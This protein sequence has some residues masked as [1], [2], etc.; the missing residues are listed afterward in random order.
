MLLLCDVFVSV[1]VF[2]Y[3]SACFS[4]SR[5]HTAIF[6]A[7]KRVSS[8]AWCRSHVLS[9]F[10]TNVQ[11]VLP[12]RPILL[13]ANLFWYIIVISVLLGGSLS[14]RPKRPAETPRFPMSTKTAPRGTQQLSKGPQN[15]PRWLRER[16]KTSPRSLR[17]SKIA[18]VDEAK[19]L[20]RNAKWYNPASGGDPPWGMQYQGVQVSFI[21]IFPSFRRRNIYLLELSLKKETCILPVVFWRCGWSAKIIAR[22]YLMYMQ[23]LLYTWQFLNADPVIRIGGSALFFCALDP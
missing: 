4:Q 18:H 10:Q 16:P 6:E 11:S 22:S 17:W 3:P 1:C 8:W 13:W 9:C 23:I 21:K 5:G 7:K 19:R 20:V 14:T 12:N 2:A 15:T